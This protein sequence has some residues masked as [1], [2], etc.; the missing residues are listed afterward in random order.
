MLN[1]FVTM[2]TAMTQG[3]ELAVGGDVETDDFPAT[4]LR[5]ATNATALVV[6]CCLVL[7]G[8]VFLTTVI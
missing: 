4:A 8:M 3:C 1:Q 6:A 5:T 7:L 2:R